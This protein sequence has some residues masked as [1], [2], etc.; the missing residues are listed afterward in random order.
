M[1]QFL[2]IFKKKFNPN[3]PEKNRI[4]FQGISKIYE[5]NQRTYFNTPKLNLKIS[6][7]FWKF[8]NLFDW[9]FI[10]FE[11]KDIFWETFWNIFAVGGL[12]LN[13][14]FTIPGK[15]Q[16]TWAVNLSF[17][18]S[19]YYS[20]WC[21]SVSLTILRCYVNVLSVSYVISYLHRS[22]EGRV[23]QTPSKIILNIKCVIINI[24]YPQVCAKIHIMETIQCKL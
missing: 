22:Q 12:Y 11:P 19:I 5:G 14:Q 7:N 1:G 23:D 18:H 10:Y 24:K 6:R 17:S 20:Y 8:W 4:H 16:I 15:A 9:K 21:S 2:E 13:W 3:Y